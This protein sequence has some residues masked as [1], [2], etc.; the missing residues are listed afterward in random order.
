MKANYF[1]VKN[2]VFDSNPPGSDFLQKWFVELDAD[3]D[4]SY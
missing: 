1:N 4:I 2:N 3:T